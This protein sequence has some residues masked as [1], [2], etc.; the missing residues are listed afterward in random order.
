[1]RYRSSARGARSVVASLAVL[2]AAAVHAAT[3]TYPSGSAP[4]NTTLQAC[5]TGAAAGDTIQI[6]TN[7]PIAETPTIDKSL[8]LQPAAGFT[9]V[10]NGSLFAFPTGAAATTI[11]VESLTINGSLRAGP[12]TGDLA[13]HFN[14][15]TVSVTGDNLAIEVSSG[16][17]PPYGNVTAEIRGNQVTATGPA[18]FCSGIGFGPI[19]DTGTSSVVIA[20]NIVT[21]TNCG[22]GTAISAT[23]GPG[24]TLSAD[25]LANRVDATGTDDGIELRNF[26]QTAGS[27]LSGRIINNLVIGQ[28][29]VAGFPGAIVVSADGFEPINNVQ[30]INNTVTGNQSGIGV[31]AR[32][33]LGASITGVVAN[34]IVANNSNIGLG[35]SSA[36]E[37][38]VS[39][40]NN[41]VFGNGSDF[42]TAGPGTVTQDPRFVSSSDFH[43]R[44]SSPAINRGSNASLPADIT[45]DLDGNPRIQLGVVD[46]GAFEAAQA[47]VSNVPALSPLGL[48]ALA[49]GL[50]LAATALLRNR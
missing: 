28:V 11:T 3:L 23:N 47:D 1:M 49:V 6:A 30:V 43:L 38:A 12:S 32:T 21:V 20:N 24:E 39:N 4:C 16:T 18:E 22:E 35:I 33:D 15:N 41:L 44:P 46:I 5:I 26:E 48:A 50:A 36:V 7:G 9:P 27:N 40:N 19:E 14:S 2:A 34:N 25:I 17:G 45:T 31:D 13:V 8:T 29:D 10:L 42:F 37:P